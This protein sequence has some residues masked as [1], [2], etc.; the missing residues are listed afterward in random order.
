VKKED[1][2]VR[3]RPAN[4]EDVG[5]IFNSWLRSYK[6]SFFSRLIDNRVYF[7]NHHKLL[8]NLAKTSTFTIACDKDD[9]SQIYGY[10][11]YE[12]IQGISAIHYIYVKHS[13][14]KLGIAKLLLKESGHT[15]SSAGCCTHITRAVEKSCIKYNL[16]YH[17]Y[18]LINSL[19]YRVSP[20][21]SKEEIAKAILNEGVD[22]NDSAE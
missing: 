10:I 2:P 13:F 6:P 21:K 14:R 3:I 18:L 16:I 19:E 15:S 5:F 12:K 1:L 17:P 7:E 20:E 22:E 4:Q 11:C 9:P 8:E